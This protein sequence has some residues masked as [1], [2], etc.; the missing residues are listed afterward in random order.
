MLHVRAASQTSVSDP[1][2]LVES[3]L[4]LANGTLSCGVGSLVVQVPTQRSA[5]PTTTCG[6]AG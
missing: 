6:K 1:E 2:L 4:A 5:M 3:I